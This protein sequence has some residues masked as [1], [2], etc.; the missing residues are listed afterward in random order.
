[1]KRKPLWVIPV[2]LAGTCLVCLVLMRLT[3]TQGGT[4]ELRQGG[5][6]IRTVPLDTDTSFTV[7]APGGGENTVTVSG[8]RICVSAADC[9]DKTCVR[10]GWVSD[11]GTPIVC[12]PHQLTILVKGGGSDVD[13]L[14]G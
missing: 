3:G 8:G 1:M 4:A 10:Q 7:Y 14:A 9:P 6:V 12:L 2:L 11:S 5:R 13:A